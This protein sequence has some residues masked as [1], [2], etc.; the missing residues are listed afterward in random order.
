M[1]ILDQGHLHPRGPRTGMS[2]MGGKHAR[3]EPFEQLVNSYLEHLPYI[4][5]V[6]SIPSVAGRYDIPI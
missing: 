5:N 6:K 3:K 4:L 1:K 2:A